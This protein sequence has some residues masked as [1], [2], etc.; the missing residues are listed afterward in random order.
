MTE[1]DD[2]EPDP[3]L[4]HEQVVDVLAVFADADSRGDLLW[5]VNDGQVS[6]AL[7]SSDLFLWACADAEEITAENM[8]HL[9]ESLEACRAIDSGMWT[10]L[11]A[12]RMRGSRPMPFKN[13]T[14]EMVALFDACGPER[15]RESYDWIHPA[16][17]SGSRSVSSLGAL[18]GP[19]GDQK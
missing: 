4:T 5:W 7:D 12:C 16:P 1:L 6:F 3:A 18:L 15:D 10:S 2:K 19:L 13:A 17:S 11:A 8:H 14:P 9:R